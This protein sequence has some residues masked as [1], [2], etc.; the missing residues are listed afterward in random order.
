MHFCL[1]LACHATVIDKGQIV[2]TAA[3]EDLK[4]G[5][6]R[7]QIPKASR[8]GTDGRRRHRDLKVEAGWGFAIRLER[9][10][11]LRQMKFVQYLSSLKPYRRECNRPPYTLSNFVA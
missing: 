2:Y 7:G 8:G 5:P 11:L 4:E 1:G 10:E 6:I 9:C 3:I